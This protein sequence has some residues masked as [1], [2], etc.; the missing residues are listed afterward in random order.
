MPKPNLLALFPPDHYALRNLDPLRSEAKILISSKKEELDEFA[1]EADIVLSSNLPGTPVRLR[2]I[3]LHS[4][5]VR[6]VHSLSAGVDNLL[7]PELIDSDVPVTNAKGVF[8]RPL[9]EFA[10]LGMLYF[11]KR[12]RRLVESQRAHHWDDFSVDGLQDKVMGVVGY[13]EIGRECALLAKPL[14]VKIHATRRKVEKA[15]N[16]PLLDRIY[17]TEQLNEMLGEVDVLLASA[18]LTDETRHMIGE[19]QFKVMKPSAIVINVGRGP[20]IEQAALIRALQNRQIA[21]AALDVFEQ[22]PLPE[23][24]PF[25]DM[26]NVLVSPH[27]ADRTHNPDWLDLAMQ[28]FVENFHRYQ[29]GRELVNVVDKRAGY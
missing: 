21:G 22:E 4:E 29:K 19:E 16:D 2:E 26:E 28:L 7:F 27:C 15:E 8:K 6:W 9:A 3:W 24:S 14:G 13:G 25:W 12:V 11:Y 5:H 23:D 17:K 20:V 1:R 18:P 10:V